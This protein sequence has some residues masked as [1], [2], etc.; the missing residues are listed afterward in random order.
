M[1]V[2]L[3]PVI[4]LLGGRVV[5]GVAGRRDEYR[6]IQS[7]LIDSTQP[8]V[9]A[10]ALIEHFLP[11]RFY[12]ADLDAIAGA[13]PAWRIYS[14]LQGL[15]ADLWIDAGV[16]SPAEAVALADA[17]I[18]GIVCGLETVPGPQELGEILAAIGAE[19]VIFSLDLKCGEPMS[20]G[21]SWPPSAFVVAQTVIGL[22][23]RRLIVLDLARVGTG[24]GTGTEELCERII[25][26]NPDI[27]LYAGGGI[28]GPED[29]QRLAACG[30][31]GAL[32]ASA[33]HDGS[34]TRA[35]AD[36]LS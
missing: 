6:P 31:R 16:R 36:P 3:V 4:D 20:I 21:A 13:P 17:A 26:A 12:I 33:L 8:R 29:L 32:V 28:R 7:R 24:V 2:E 30:V 27:E 5:R 25:E 22:G 14:E 9:I 11:A 23:I 34:I 10:Q 35:D 15:G 1:K 18:D 19:R